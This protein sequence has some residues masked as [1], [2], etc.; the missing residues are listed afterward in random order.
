MPS[1]VAAHHVLSVVRVPWCGRRLTVHLEAVKLNTNF[2]IALVE[3]FAI[4]GKKKWCTL[5]WEWIDAIREKIS[6]KVSKE[7][8]GNRGE[9]EKHA[10]SP[11]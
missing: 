1:L 9:K 7:S 10:A 3:H 2:P 6:M 11:G 5:G 8:S 4:K